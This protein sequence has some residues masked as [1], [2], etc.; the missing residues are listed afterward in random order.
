[1]DRSLTPEQAAKRA[2]CG[3]S[4]IMRAL[5]NGDLPGTRDNRNRW[6]IDPQDVDRWSQNR[7]DND[8]SQTA[9]MTGQNVD[10]AR[11]AALE[12]ENG[13]LRE[14]LNEMRAERDHWRQIAS[15][16][17]AQTEILVPKVMRQVRRWW[18]WR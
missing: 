9:D 13:Q 10:I 3:R 7:P 18:P 11:T 5:K 14:R 12:A 6:K 4:S 17:S 15:N 16:L 1:M 2:N 8:R